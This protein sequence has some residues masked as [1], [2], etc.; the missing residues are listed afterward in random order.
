MEVLVGVVF[1]H[2]MASELVARQI[3]RLLIVLGLVVGVRQVDH[4]L[5]PLRLG[6]LILVE[7]PLHARNLRVDLCD[8][9]HTQADRQALFQEALSRHTAEDRRRNGSG[10]LNAGSMALMQEPLPFPLSL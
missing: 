4:L 10:L 5:L 6:R 9:V 3:R 8:P 2:E 1:D 7:L